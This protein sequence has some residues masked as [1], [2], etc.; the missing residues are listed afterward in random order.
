MRKGRQLSYKEVL[1]EGVINLTPLI[2]V[3][4]VV[5]IMFIIVAP[6]LE[7]DH[8][9]LAAKEQADRER[10]PIQENSHLVIHVHADNTIWINK[11]RV[12]E[13]DLL[14]LLK[15]EKLNHPKQ[16]PQLFHDK[17]AFFGTYQTVKNSLER[18]G[19]EEIALFLQPG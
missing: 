10:T 4:F 9:E 12:S 3:V 15:R 8:V 13:K 6:M 16:I 5:L 7:V 17:K 11:Q 1:E 14:P 19:F 2:D 18:A